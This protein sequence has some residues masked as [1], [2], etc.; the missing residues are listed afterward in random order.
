MFNIHNSIDGCRKVRNNRLNLAI[1]SSLVSKVTTVLLQLVS[2]PMAIRALGMDL[3]SSYSLGIAITSVLCFIDFGVGNG[4]TRLIA[5]DSDKNNQKKIISAALA[6]NIILSIIMLAL[7]MLLIMVDFVK[8]W[9]PVCSEAFSAINNVVLA[10]SCII[11]INTIFNTWIRAQAGMQEVHVSNI[12]NACGNIMSSLFVLAAVY[13]DCM[14]VTLLTI[15]VFGLP[16]IAVVA[17]ACYLLA[18]RDTFRPTLYADHRKYIYMLLSDGVAFSLTGTFVVFIQRELVKTVVAKIAGLNAAGMLSALIQFATYAN[19]I[20]TMI[21][22]PIMPGITDAYQIGDKVW[23]KNIVK[24]ISLYYIA[25]F[26][27]GLCIVIIAGPFILKVL[28]GAEFVYSRYYILIFSV[29]FGLIVWGQLNAV[30]VSAIG[31]VWFVAKVLTAE[32]L[33]GLL[34]GAYLVSKIGYIGICVAWILASLMLS[35]WLLPKIL[36]KNTRI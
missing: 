22:V 18:T 29:G 25:A 33:I 31:K 3:Y 32:S 26:M 10:S 20:I 15:G 34:F 14:S 8:Y 5:K 4:V 1:V 11:I 23:V 27:L 13:F 7:V 24:R 9:S 21:T 28:M 2:V 6:L 30:F 35:S 17:N 12:Y 19:G 36:N 16:C